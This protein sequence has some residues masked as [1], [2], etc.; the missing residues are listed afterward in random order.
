MKT[1]F[2]VSSLSI[3]H[4]QHSHNQSAFEIFQFEISSLM[5]SILLP[6]VAYKSQIRNR[7]KIKFIRLDISNQRMSEIMSRDKNV[8]LSC[9]PF[10]LGY[11]RQRRA[12]KMPSRPVLWQ[13]VKILS[14]PVPWQDFELVPLSLCPGTI[15]GLLSLCPTGKENLVPL[16][17][18]IQD[19]QSESLRTQ[20]STSVLR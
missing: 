19:S 18:I 10:V 3:K 7:L 6:A 15:K 14:Q 17:T 13:N 1:S 9:C 12:V 5:N 16:E 2:R 11:S 20:K 4:F 8:Y